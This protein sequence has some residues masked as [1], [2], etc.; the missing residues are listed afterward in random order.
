MKLFNCISLFAIC[1][2]LFACKKN[3]EDLKTAVGFPTVTT[4]DIT[5]INTTSATGGGNISDDGGSPITA[6]GVIWSTGTSTPVTTTDGTATGSFSSN[7]TGLSA[8]KT[9]FVKAYA[10][11]ANGTSYGNVVSFTTI[12]GAPVIPGENDPI[13]LG[14]PTNAQTLVSTPENYLKDNVYY[15]LAYSQSRGIPVWVAWHLQSEDIGTASRQ[16]DFRGDVN[17]PFG[18]YQVQNTSYIGANFDRGHNCPSADRTST[19]AANSSTFLMTNMIPQAPNFN[20]GPWAGLED[21]IRNSLVGTGYEAYIAMGNFGKGGYNASGTLVN[22]IDSGNVTVPAK[23]WKV[24][25]LLPKGTSDLSR[26]NSSTIVLTVNM[27]NDNRLYTTGG[28]STW[29]NYLTTVTNLENEANAAGVPLNLF[30]SVADSVR[31]ILKAKLYP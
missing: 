9:Y 20:Q 4:N 26:I 14:N 12:S 23:V 7:I 13:F 29:R 15:K 25:L 16:D 3:T 8:T 27:P 10:S 17:L 28:T 22:N 21:F 31:P 5:A 6:R 11:N 2:L 30:K 1:T 18:W 19:I 24:V